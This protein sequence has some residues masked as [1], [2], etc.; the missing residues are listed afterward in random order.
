VFRL[1]NVLLEMELVSANSGLVWALS[2]CSEM[3]HII[4]L[5][6]LM[7][8]KPG[9]FLRFSRAIT[10]AMIRQ[11]YLVAFGPKYFLMRACDEL[12]EA[13]PTIA[14][15][16]VRMEAIDLNRVAAD[17]SMCKEIRE[18][19]DARTCCETWLSRAKLKPRLG[20]K[21]SRSDGGADDGE[22][23]LS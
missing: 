15:V 18:D 6:T 7:C 17:M 20:E 9:R 23:V 4:P 3:T 1:L 21:K 19:E 16:A 2:R 12:R 13:M 10:R 5:S 11:A 14:P 22:C 8:Q